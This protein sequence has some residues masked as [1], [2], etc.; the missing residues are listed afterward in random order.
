MDW[1]NDQDPALIESLFHPEDGGLDY[2][3]ALDIL[4][5]RVR[6]AKRIWAKPPQ[7]DLVI[8]R[9]AYQG[10]GRPV[11]W[12]YRQENCARTM[13]RVGHM[14]GLPAPPEPDPKHDPLADAVAQAL[15]VC[16]V[17]RAITSKR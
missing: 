3:E 8:L 10:A 7:F 2:G 16:A 14:L 11:P 15:G 5:Q 9:S 6:R 13:L 12:H 17:W 4:A 1:W